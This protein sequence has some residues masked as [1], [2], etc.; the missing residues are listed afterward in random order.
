MRAVTGALE[1]AAVCGLGIA[2]VVALAGPEP[3]QAPAAAASV[4]GCCLLVLAA[5]VH[6]RVAPGPTDLDA[7]L[8]VE[9]AFP[10]LQDR[11]ATA[12]DL[13]GRDVP[14]G[15]S[16][17]IAL[18]VLTEAGAALDDL[19]L[20]RALPVRALR[21]PAL[22]AVG[23]VCALAVALLT[24]P[25][26]GEAGQFAPARPSPA[27]IS[28]PTLSPAPR[29]F[30]LT[31]AIG[32][33]AYTGLPPR[34]MGADAGTIRAMLGSRITV[35]ASADPPTLAVR[36]SLE[37][38]G[39]RAMSAIA[40]GRSSSA[41]TLTERVVCGL[42]GSDGER[43]AETPRLV[44]EPT[45][46][47]PPDVRLAD[48]ARDLTLDAPEG[49][50]VTVAAADDFAVASFGLRYRL[51]GEDAWR[52]LDLR[53]RPGRDVTASARLN[54][55]AVGVRPGKALQ[56]RAWATDNDTVS[57]PK[58]SVSPAITIRVRG[59]TV[60]D[61]AQTPVQ[62]AEREQADAFEQMQ[63]AAEQ[64]DRELTDAIQRL[65]GDDVSG[66][67]LSEISTRL[68]EAAQRLQ[69][70][71]AQVEVAMGQ[72]EAE[73]SASDL[74]SPEIVEKVRELHE[75]MREAMSEEL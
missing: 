13:A 63:Q 68:Q 44:I 20:G 26:G 29:L 61:Q 32:P 70:Q 66:R 74:V 52:S 69:Q 41:F 75:L 2:A 58:T 7:A 65:G 54:L 27:P 67:E 30:D 24:A 57:G 71:A 38:G 11:V 22:A 23:G 16:S 50:D 3:L 45:A 8:T 53:A 37:P 1:G 49:I 56:L 51:E 25:A 64:F 72:L 42:T 35:A 36:L 6:R 19:P 59:E 17:R 28:H 14:P 60:S 15:T 47:A 31:V 73:L 48:P 5:A 18:R 43:T 62:E 40:E 55:G 9:H 33:P 46:D 34:T 39:V 21:R 4:L 10:F 12:V